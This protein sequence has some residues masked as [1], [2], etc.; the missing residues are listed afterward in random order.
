[1]VPASTLPRPGRAGTADRRRGRGAR[2]R[3]HRY[4]GEVGRRG[5]PEEQRREQAAQVGVHLDQL[6]VD[7]GAR[8]AAL[9]VR[10]DP[11][12]L[13]AGEAVAD[14]GAEVGAGC[15]AGRARLAGVVHVHR[16]EG[17]AQPLAGPVG[18]LGDRVGGEAEQRRDLG[19]A[20]ALD[21]GVPQHQ[22]PA[23]GQR[24]ERA[25]RGIGLEA[26]DRGVAERAGPRRGRVSSSVGLGAAPRRGAGRRRAVVTAVSR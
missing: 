4:V 6:E 7:R 2:R 15:L 23:L 21:L 11:G 13:P 16:H 19:W 22:L 24:G 1:M 12:R 5:A 9:E 20:L 8:A 26:G 10:R 14:V 3:G 25:R 18:E 17:L